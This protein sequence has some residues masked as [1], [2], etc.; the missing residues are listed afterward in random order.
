MEFCE[1]AGKLGCSS[2]S[3]TLKCI[4]NMLPEENE[5]DKFQVWKLVTKRFLA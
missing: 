3:L 4:Q 2:D 5:I 1:G